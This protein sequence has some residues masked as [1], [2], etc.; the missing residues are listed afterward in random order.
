MERLIAK[1]DKEIAE[2]TVERK[3]I[4]TEMNKEKT[5]FSRLEES[6]KKYADVD[7]VLRAREEEWLL[8]SEELDS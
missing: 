4:Q 2:L 5:D 3:S 6:A 7:E 1:I 8:L